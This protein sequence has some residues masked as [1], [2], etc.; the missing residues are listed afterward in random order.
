MMRELLAVSEGLAGALRVC[1]GLYL[2]SHILEARKPEKRELAAA[3]FAGACLAAAVFLTDIPKLYGMAAEAA[4]ICGAAARAQKT[5]RRLSLFLSV[6][7][8]IAVYLWS[9][10]TA[11]FVGICARSESFLDRRKP[12]GQAAVWC[13][14]LA[15]LAILAILLLRRCLLRKKEQV[16]EQGASKG[17]SRAVSLLAAAGFVVSVTLSEQEILV[18]S[19]NELDVCLLFSLLLL[20]AVMVFSMN[21]QYRAEQELAEMKAEQ[22]RLLERDYTALNRV[23]EMNA[24]LFHDLHRHLGALHQLLSHEKYG[25]ALRYLDEL[26]EPA[27]EMTDRAWTGE[28]TVDYLIGTRAAAAAEKQIRFQ[29]EAEFPRHTGIRDADL[30]AVLGNLLDN[31]LEAAEKVEAAEGRWVRLTMRGIHQMLVIRVENG[32]QEKP[33]EERG[34]WKSTKTEG[35]LHGWGL[36]SARIA[37]EKYEGTVSTVCEQNVFRA[38]ATLC[39]RLSREEISGD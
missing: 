16:E 38:T 29:A 15:A 28:E 19:K 27:R 2:I 23:Y 32:F 12:E 13:F 20:V 26:Q 1:A 22:A 25:E 6:F 8:E 11:A 24:R 10:L 39:F 14:Y 21:R 4:L 37:A 35:G 5:E 30:C 7:Y 3:G 36:K 33:V 17:G 31:A 9:F 18:F 34:E